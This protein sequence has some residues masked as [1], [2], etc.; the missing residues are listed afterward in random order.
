[1]IS[2]HEKFMSLAIKQSFKSIKEG[3]GQTDCIIV[4]DNLIIQRGH[5]HEL[6]E[7]DPTAH[8]EIMTIRKLCKKLKTRNLKG[9]TLYSTLQPCGMCTLACI[10]AGVTT[11][12]Y[13][14]KRKDVEARYF[15]QKHSDTI[16]LVQES[17]KTNIK[18]IPGI[19]EEECS[20]L[21]N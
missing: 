21:Y 17:Y 9:Y 10:W 4:K 1:M 6:T 15:D 7:I 5:N 3:N 11:I 2:S 19:L 16:D 18:I 14:A 13:G 20:K 12:V 8:A